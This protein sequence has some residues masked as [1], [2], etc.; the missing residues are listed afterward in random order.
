MKSLGLLVFTLFSALPAAA[1]TAVSVPAIGMVRDGDGSVRPVLGTAGNF[2]TGDAVAT[3]VVSAAFA[4][5]SGFI[6]TDSELLVVDEQMHVIAHYDAPPGRATFRFSVTGR[7]AVVYY[8][9]TGTSLDLGET[10][11]DNAMS[12]TAADHTLFVRA[13]GGTERRIAIHF[14]VDCFEPM[15]KDWVAVHEAGSARV[16]ALRT[17][18]ADLELYQLPDEGAR[19]TGK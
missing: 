14:D 15:G 8:A 10:P 13:P 19:E 6:K 9:D 7:P 1:Q 2:L 17:N 12:V 4:G 3:G 16:F 11:D 18:K 5:V